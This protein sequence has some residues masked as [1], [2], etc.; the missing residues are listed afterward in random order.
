MDKKINSAINQKIDM[1]KS[2]I[3][4]NLEAGVIK[5]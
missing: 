2:I 3:L 1:F 5:T 4:I